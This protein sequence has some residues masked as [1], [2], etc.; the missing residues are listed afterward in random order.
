MDYDLF[1]ESEYPLNDKE[2]Y[3]NKEKPEKQAYETY[4]KYLKYDN[5]INSY[6]TDIKLEDFPF[7]NRDYFYIRFKFRLKTPYI[8]KGMNN[9]YVPFQ[10]ENSKNDVKYIFTENPIHRDKAFGIPCIEPSTWKG[11]LRNAFRIEHSKDLSFDPMEKELFGNDREEKDVFS[12]GGL[13]VYPTFFYQKDNIDLEIINPIDRKV[14]KTKEKVGPIYVECVPADAQGDFN[15]L[16]FPRDIENDDNEEET[17]EKN[18]NEIFSDLLEVAKTIKL[19]FLTLGIGAKTSNGFGLIDDVLV[20]SGEV[21]IN[22]RNIKSSKNQQLIPEEYHKFMEN[23]NGE[24]KPWEWLFLGKKL[25]SKSKYI[26]RKHKYINIQ[27]H[28]YTNKKYQQ[29]KNWYENDYLKK[30]DDDTVFQFET[31]TQLVKECVK[32]EGGE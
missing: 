3:K 8:S 16:Y 17:Q 29:F 23:I 2:K 32:R 10:R 20:E 5:N 21:K 27:D 11:V 7:K 15:L 4:K 28:Q 24:C 14:R 31:I 6:I 1:L 19:A 26:E 18:E 25:I 30:S 13:Y 9:Y 22:I 12:Q